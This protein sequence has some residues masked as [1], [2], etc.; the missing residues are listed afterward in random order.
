[1]SSGKT[2]LIIGGSG[3]L[4]TQL[5]LRLRETTKVFA[6]YHRN[7]IRIPGVTPL[8]MNLA[9]L[10]WVKRSIYTVGP[11]AVVYAVGTNN[12]WQAQLQSKEQEQLQVGALA[13]VLKASTIFQPRFVYL[14]SSYAFDGIRGNY[15]E[16]D[17][18][19]SAL[20]LGKIKIEAENFVR[21]RALHYSVV[22]SSPVIARGCGG[23]LSFF[24]RLR[25]RL[26]RGLKT[27]V[28]ATELHSFTHMDPFLDLVERIIESGPRNQVHHLGGLTKCT[29]FDLSK[30]IAHRLGL[31]AG[32]LYPLPREQSSTRVLDQAKWDFSLNST[33]SIR[34]LRVKPLLLEELVER[35]AE[36]AI[37]SGTGPEV[38]VR[39][40]SP[41]A[42]I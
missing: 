12:L 28:D 16:Q 13:P 37:T 5:A 41:G 20:A 39:A 1:M 35:L 21:G 31:D 17:T 18:V 42:S 8:P 34:N 14:S 33:E 24:D 40:P 36:E 9:D 30:A 38:K 32:L 26:S 19:L 4:G 7:P 23:N 22:R 25:I 3:F 6:T 29:Y 27:G 10:D 15:R 2:V 11:D